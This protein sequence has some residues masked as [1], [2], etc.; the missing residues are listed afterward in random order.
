MRRGTLPA[1]LT[2]L[3][4]ACGSLLVARQET[5]GI[6]LG[7]TL[8]APHAPATS[9]SPG[10]VY[11]EVLRLRRGDA[12]RVVV[13]QLG[14]DVALSLRNPRGGVVVA[15]DSPNGERGEE[16]L[17]AVAERSG[18]FALE[19]A[20]QPR[21]L[22]GGFRKRLVAVRPATAADRR[23]A[24]A[25]LDFYAGERA[26][27]RRDRQGREA[28]VEHY[29]RALRAQLAAAD[30]AGA[31][32]SAARLSLVHLELGQ[33]PDARAAC[34]RALELGLEDRDDLLSAISRL[35][36]L[37]YRLGAPE[38]AVRTLANS[39]AL[40][41]PGSE[42]L[43]EA[44][45]QNN[46]ALAYQ[47][48]GEHDEAE[49]SFR[50]ALG[51]WRRLGSRCDEALATAN[52]GE[53]YLELGHAPRALDLFGRA[54][55]LGC[56]R[57]ERLI[58]LLRAQAMAYERLGRR[59]PARRVYARAL[60]L[61]RAS[62]RPADG[63]L[64]LNALGGLLLGDG[65]ARRALAAHDEA[66]QLA[67]AGRDLRGQANALANLG[68]IHERLGRPREGLPLLARSRALYA[69]LGEPSSE[70]AVL[71]GMAL[72]QREVG[73]LGEAR[74]SIEAAVG[75]LEAL[76]L[77]V[78]GAAL[79]S[80][81]VEARFDAYELA[82]DLLM[83]LHRRSPGAGFD[84]AAF[85]AAERGRARTL[86]EGLA[87][88]G[89]PRPP[90]GLR[91]IQLELADEDTLLLAY[92][93]AEERSFAWRVDRGGLAAYELP[94][95]AEVEALTRRAHRLLGR[96]ATPSAR[97]QARAALAELS[98]RV[99][100]PL[101][102]RGLPGRVL[103]VADGALASIPF[104]ALPDPAS[105]RDP[106]LL[107]HEVV[108]LH[109]ASVLS[110]IRRRH[111][112]AAAPERLVVV[113]ADPVFGPEDSRLAP[114][115]H[116]PAPR[117]PARARAVEELGLAALRRL[118][119]SG[120]EAQRIL[121]LA[122]PGRGRG[123][124]GFEATRRNLAAAALGEYRI[125][126]FA[127]HAVAHSDP[128]LSSVVLSLVDRGGAPRDGL[129]RADELASLDL[130]AELVVLSACHTAAGAEVRGEGVFSLSRAALQAGAR[131]VLV[132]L[133]AADDEATAELMTLFY[134]GLLHRG[135]S[136]AAAL[137]EAQLTM[138]RHPRWSAPAYWAGFVLEGDWRA[139][140]LP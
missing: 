98:T 62:G 91:Q 22:R 96:S 112:R 124:S 41:M 76:R 126:H 78:P 110:E 53:L 128:R 58:P 28:A 72:A 29:G 37:Q 8:R 2:L 32:R 75:R 99:L 25:A 6:A 136:P 1:L 70:A 109:S 73:R 23:S 123:L 52:L 103:V 14:S 3:A 95:R 20:L 85:E 30:A 135:L 33:Y 102:G 42:P 104:A 137:R 43:Y 134:R 21:A 113:V 56:D 116:P 87:V 88:G 50:R 51:I 18:P 60:V 54:L 97:E 107:G 133:W 12:V 89:A 40:S 80:S 120:L 108:S 55:A 46:L 82:V 67:V 5:S 36:W 10:P 49:R 65:Q 77:Q 132:S 13:E 44:G 90:L 129:L 17:L 130:R 59:E 31:A 64:V 7:T 61:A 45:A 83:R 34:V 66:L 15:S 105:P 121:S 140:P 39:P 26:R 74:E 9:S 24:A 27:K 81:F 38:A 4:A 69:R 118:P 93:L 19:I 71:Y 125:V 11:R 119:F 138:R 16:K 92:F 101:A 127:T 131:R 86:L 115:A 117:P 35:G 100:A 48:M 68:H 94:A 106:L 111:T 84:V 122:P 114:A 139:M 79:R 47:A 63:A 57:E